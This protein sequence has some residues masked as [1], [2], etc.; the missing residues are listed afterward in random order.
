MSEMQ[1]K[2]QSTNCVL[3]TPD[4]SDTS[5]LQDNID[6]EGM[7]ENDNTKCNGLNLLYEAIEGVSKTDIFFERVSKLDSTSA[8]TNKDFSYRYSHDNQLKKLS[9]QDKLNSQ[10]ISN[11]IDINEIHNEFCIFIRQKYGY[12]N[13]NQSKGTKS[14]NDK[15]SKFHFNFILNQ[16]QSI[17]YYIY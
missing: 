1:Q 6:T 7:N 3:S 16:S 15:N 9:S 13:A 17:L 11:K 10:F 5:K 2:E 12:S 8:S 14:M 4:L